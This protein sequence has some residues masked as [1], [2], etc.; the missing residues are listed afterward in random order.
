MQFGLGSHRGVGRVI[1]SSG[2]FL[3]EWGHPTS[4][5]GRIFLG[6]LFFVLLLGCPAKEEAACRDNYLVTHGRVA[7]T[8]VNDLE[9]AEATRKAVQE[10]LSLCQKAS[11]QQETTELTTVLRKLESQVSYLQQRQARKELTPEELARYVASGDPR[12]PKGQSYQS[13]KAPQKIKCVGPQVLH[14]NFAEARE[15]FLGRGFKTSETGNIVTFEF[16]AESYRYTFPKK[17]ETASCVVVFSQ[18][19]IAWQETVAR[20]TGLP[21][22]RL[23]QGQPLTV[24]ERQWRFDV[25]GDETQAVLRFG[26]TCQ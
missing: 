9:S 26:E 12:C 5:I 3:A 17:E 22:K 19:G 1:P 20:L 18:P 23:K 2:H 14:M 8:D 13:K 11:L 25:S 6:P 15:Y 16:G 24:G 7:E 4:G 10:N 21:P